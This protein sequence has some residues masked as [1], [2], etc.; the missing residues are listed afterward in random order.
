MN[1]TLLG[2]GSLLMQDEGVGV[3]AVRYIQENYDIPGLEIVDGGTGGM[4]LLPYIE[5]RDRLLVLDAANFGKEPGYIGILRNEEVPALFGVKA[6]LHH[7]GLADVLAAAQLLDIAP[8]EICL[9]G[10]QPQ[11]IA[12]GLELTALIQEKLLELVA[13]TIKQ[14]EEWGVSCRAVAVGGKNSRQ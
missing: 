9:I 3:H 14:L 4:D 10:I 5:N 1:I 7:L 2:L 8:K 6:S 11:T 13:L 12:L